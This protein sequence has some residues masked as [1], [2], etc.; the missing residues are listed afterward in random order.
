MSYEP[1]TTYN[2]GPPMA[3]YLGAMNDNSVCS[4][5]R[6][7][8]KLREPLSFSTL[9]DKDRR[10]R[11]EHQL[12]PASSAPLDRHNASPLG[13]NGQSSPP[14]LHRWTEDSS[15]A[16]RFSPATSLLR[17]EPRRN[18]SPP[19]PART[20][21][22]LGMPPAGNGRKRAVRGRASSPKRSEVEMVGDQ[23]QRGTVQQEVRESSW[24]APSPADVFCDPSAAT[25]V[26]KPY[27]PFLIDPTE[28]GWTEGASTRQFS[29]TTLLLRTMRIAFALRDD[30]V[31]PLMTVVLPSTKTIPEASVDRAYQQAASSQVGTG[32]VGAPF[33]S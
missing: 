17:S 8:D 16:L 12:I 33:G 15:H 7:S 3:A 26:R 6:I 27:I 24:P 13:T 19:R 18:I 23:P 28:G 1:P 21:P 10:E 32:R 9:E 22:N 4:V 30:E 25:T 5:K 11:D 29:S 20:P 31:V 14:K 2:R